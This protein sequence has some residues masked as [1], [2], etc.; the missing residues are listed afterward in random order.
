MNRKNLLLVALA[1]LLVALGNWLVEQGAKEVDKRLAPESVV[2]QD[3]YLN[4]VTITAFDEKGQ[5]QH[6]LQASQLSHITAAEQTEIQQPDLE[7]LAQN[8]VVWHVVAERG[9]INVQQDLVLLQGKVNLTQ[10][11]KG[12]PLRLTTSALR[13]Q[14]KRGRADTDQPV[15]LTQGNSRIDAVGMNIDQ[16]EQRLL[17]LSQVRG[18]YEVLT[19]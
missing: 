13:I 15:S 1:L 18:R 16:Q 12:T 14:P 5:P 7:V 11:D 10:P 17:L 2:Q 19:P 8:K 3:Y 6:R 4:E 9:E